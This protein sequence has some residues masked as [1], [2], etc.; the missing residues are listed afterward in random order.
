MCS[1]L[2]AVPPRVPQSAREIPVLATVDVVIVGGT[3]G[4]VS[5][6]MAARRAGA[7]VYLVAPRT[8]LGEGLCGSLHL[9]QDKAT[10]EGELARKLLTKGSP[11]PPMHVKRTLSRAL[12]AQGIPFLFASTASDVL[13]DGGGRVAGVVIANRAGRQAIVAKA[14]IDASERSTVAR[15]AGGEIQGRTRGTLPAERVVLVKADEPQAKGTQRIPFTSGKLALAYEVHQLQLD[16]PDFS[17]ASLAQAEQTA[18]DRTYRKGQFRASERLRVSWPD[19]VGDVSGIFVLGANLWQAGKAEALGRSLGQAAAEDALARPALTGV[20]LPGP[21]RAGRLDVGEPLR[22]ARPAS[23]PARTVPAAASS[24]PIW[25]EVD[26]L[27]VGGGTTG[28]PAAIAAARRGAKVL[29]IEFQ[30]GLGGTGTLGMI[31]KAYHG[32]SAG[33]SK[34]VPFPD[35]SFR[36][37]D[38]MEWF[39]HEIRAAGGQIWFGTM[40]CGAL[41][42]G[43]RVCGAVVANAAGRGAVL[44]KVVIDATGSA[45]LAVAAGAGSLA[46][47]AGDSVAV[48]GAGLPIRPPGKY[49]VNT[50]YLLVDE[51]DMVDTSRAL[52]GALETM[53]GNAYDV[54]P[55]LQT[56]E[57]RRVVGDH[58]LRY[59]DQIAGRT[60]PD[61]IVFSASDYDSHGYPSSPYFALLPHD[62]K[63]VK[64]NHPAPGGSCY[65]PYRCLLPKGLEGILVV[66]LGISMERDASAMVRMQRDLH[67]QGYAAGVAAAMGAKRGL[68]PR[69]IPVRELQEHLVETGSLPAAALGHRDSFPLAEPLVAAAVADLS[70]DGAKARKQVCHALAVVLTHAELALPLLRRAHAKA[71][72]D[73]R[74]YYARVLGML[75]DRAAGPEL[76]AALAATGEWEPRI[77][78]GAMAEYAHLPTPVDGVILA[79]GRTRDPKAVPV[80]LAKLATLDA[81]VTLS[82][83][84][85]LALALEQ[86]ADPRAAAPLAQLL[87]KPGMGGHALPEIKPLH[88]R[89]RKLRRRIGPLRE[90]VLARALYHC[91]DWQ[92]VGRKV[93]TGYTRDLR[94]IFARHAHHVLSQE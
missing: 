88:D 86:L 92:G 34:E 26:V 39:R 25:A 54:G 81:S 22:G 73:T 66:G 85:A 70:L 36:V 46:S 15:L 47:G 28:A 56:R 67:N 35:E 20:H 62:A 38:K 3:V 50:D 94:G 17:P 74:L 37:E 2:F 30:E 79:L 82:H 9:W 45:D 16:Y 69:Q 77:L 51:T 19:L 7:S 12:L 90:I 4:A 72:G 44:A 40:G 49:Y 89:N 33:F 63:T 91:G 84:R 87:A 10:P 93:L 65:T 61:S 29:V 32:R 75:G 21:A 43:T 80:L 68:T 31:G 14:V 52:A 58:I 60:Y 6:A 13:R 71:E 57:R 83:H 11:I 23:D 24:V 27:V 55:L 1:S 42:A 8:Y 41:L 78:Q 48:Q 53:R 18:R 76:I 59:L 5:A 64:M